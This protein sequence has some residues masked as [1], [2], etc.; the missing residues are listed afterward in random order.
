MSN[1]LRGAIVN[2]E[3]VRGK[4]AYEIAV[5][6]GFDGSEQEWLDYVYGSEAAKYYNNMSAQHAREAEDARDA[7]LQTQVQVNAT[8]ESVGKCLVSAKTYAE[9]AE[10][11]AAVYQGIKVENETLTI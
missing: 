10:A 9:R 3:V 5:A 4:S 1:V 11:S 2:P 8:A 6:H 7:T